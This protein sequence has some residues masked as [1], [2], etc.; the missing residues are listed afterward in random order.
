MKTAVPPSDDESAGGS[1]PAA[2]SR[3]SR[4]VLARDALAG[5]TVALVLIPQALAYAGVAGMPPI[6]GLYAAAVPP[7]AAALFASSPYLQTGPVALTSLLTFGALA[8]RA[9]VGSDAYVQLGILLALVVGVVRVLIG[10][11]RGGI[12]AH[13]MSEPMLIGFMPA[14]AI[15]I[16]ASQMPAALGVKPP[17]GSGVV[18]GA[19]GALTSPGDW[20]LEAV[21]L[22][23]LSLTVIF[24]GRRLHR[25][26]PG[27]LV[28]LLAGLALSIAGVYDGAA[29]GDIPS[30]LP[31]FTLDL[32]YGELPSLI[33]PG[34]VIAVVGFAEA[35]SISRTYAIRERRPW[36]A[37]REFFS[38][39]AANLASGVSGGY[40]V[41][42]SFSRSALNHSA[43]AVTR[44]SGAI[45]GLAVLIFL[46]FASV[47]E[48]LPKAV[49]SAIVISAVLGLM[50]LGRLVSLWPVSRPQFAVAVTTFA[51]TLLLA[52]HVEQAVLAGVGLAL[53]VHLVRELTLRIETS[54]TG[55]TLEIR[56]SGVLWFATAQD[57]EERLSGLLEQHPEVTRLRLALDGL[58]R[59]DLTGVMAL[60]RLLDDASAGG[61]EVEVTGAPPQARGLLD[62]YQRGK[63]ALS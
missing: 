53:A 4:A 58:G 55:D 45:T 47:L 57:L 25:L 15:L 17:E 7:L 31:P 14:S 23:L 22:A 16:A 63:D 11:L 18:D 30:G 40:P 43:G 12:I 5:I 54:V 56:P 50:R 10:V 39:G 28:V 36:S 21:V 34:A 35:A 27:V 19:L 8:G 46:P 38:Q 41:G 44:A 32:P 13:L 42:G 61:I 9:P 52:P 6:G 24:G 49:L 59:I 62:R 48:P 33:F 26:F 20:K 51:L 3:P 1:D 2:S 29:V 60:H 37:D